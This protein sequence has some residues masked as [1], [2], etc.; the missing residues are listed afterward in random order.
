MSTMRALSVE[1]ICLLEAAPA[2]LAAVQAR[3]AYED[4]Q[5]TP[6]G[7][8]CRWCTACTWKIKT[9]EREAL[10]ACRGL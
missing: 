9:L 5:P 2:L 6:W 3:H 1:Q 10:E 8:D 7:H 4:G